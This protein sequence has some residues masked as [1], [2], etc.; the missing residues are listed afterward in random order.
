MARPH[1]CFVQAQ[2]LPWR[3]R[4]IAGATL[5][6]KTLSRDE[7][8]GAA[9]EILRLPPGFWRAG[10]AAFAATFEFYVLQGAFSLGDVIYRKDSYA[11][12]PAGTG[13]SGWHA[14]DGA[15]VLAMFDAAPAV[16]APRPKGH[17]QAIVHR[18]AYTMPWTTG[19]QGSVTGKPLSPT[20]FTKKLRVDE[21][22]GEQTF[23]YAALP[24]HPPPKVMPGK[25][26]HPVIEEI[27]CLSGEYVFGD[28]GKMG[29]GGYCWWREGAWHGPAGSETGYN[30]LIRVHG[31]PLTN[32]FSAEPSPFS[33]TPAHAPAL[34]P[35]MMQYDA[36]FPFADTW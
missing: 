17:A 2:A 12:L 8:T 1:I 23:L 22:T 5:E 19:A 14:R 36:P 25:F 4:M 27:F 30:L 31:G 10:P 13:W 11:Y 28:V 29:P 26:T 9:T 3:T 35:D 15:V 21:A 6:A 16:A 20:I 34:P 24:H 18:D 33:F 7:R 32:Q